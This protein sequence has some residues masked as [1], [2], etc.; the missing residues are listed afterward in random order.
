MTKEKNIY[1]C[2]PNIRHG[3]GL[4]LLEMIIK[5]AQSLDFSIGGN[6]NSALKKNENIIDK[7]MSLEFTNSGLTN[8]LFPLLHTKKHIDLENQIILFFGNL[9]P[10]SKMKGKSFLYIHSKLLLEPVFRYKL[11]IKTRIRLIFEKLFIFLFYKNVDLIVVQTPSMMQLSRDI[12]KKRETI[13]LPFFDYDKG[14]YNHNGIKQLDFFYPSYGYTYKNHKNLLQAFTLLS[15]RNIFPSIALALDTKIDTELINF[16]TEE[17]EK[18]NLKIELVLDKNFE[19][20]KDYYNS[21][22][23]LVWPS[24]TE[25]LGMPLI[26]ASVYEKDILASDLEYVHDILEIKKEDCFN[27]NDPLSIADCM[28]NYIS[29]YTQGDKNNKIKLR[30]YSTKDFLNKLSMHTLK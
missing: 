1:I 18:Y 20:M 15:E 12:F 17:S 5:A 24:F 19:Q 16:I 11:N 27:P 28:E 4:S 21:C 6:L 13:C 3:G 7:T 10:I 30:I 25:S 23:A 14:V 2:A 8:Y 9:P 22:K 29:R 26:E